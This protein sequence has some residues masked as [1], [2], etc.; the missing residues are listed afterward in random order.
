[1]NPQS[2]LFK[3]MLSLALLL[4]TH[5]VEAGIDSQLAAKIRTQ[6]GVSIKDEVKEIRKEIGGQA[7]RIKLLDNQTVKSLGLSS[8][9]KNKTDDGELFIFR[10]IAVGY[11]T[12]ATAGATGA[13]NKTYNTDLPATLRNARLLVKVGN[14]TK[15]FLPLSEL[16]NYGVAQDTHQDYYQT[17]GFNYW[18]SGKDISIEIELPDGIVIPDTEEHYIEV[19][20]K[21]A[22]VS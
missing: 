7:N 6:K 13:V 8:F 21:G 3:T 14:D 12:E 15:L 2:T 19:R 10:H 17:I 22:I 11:A 16:A 1:M 18:G 9:D 4:S 20:I 5:A